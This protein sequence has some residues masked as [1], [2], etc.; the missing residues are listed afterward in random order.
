M[1]LAE[2]HEY[3]N[4]AER[5]QLAT[6]EAQALANETGEAVYVASQA[7]KGGKTGVHVLLASQCAGFRDGQIIERFVFPEAV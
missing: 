5:L 4:I 6:V 3:E 7:H 2:I 1:T